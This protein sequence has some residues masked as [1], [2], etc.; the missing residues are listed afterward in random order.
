MADV[1]GIVIMLVTRGQVGAGR[2][3]GQRPLAGSVADR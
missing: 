2:A 1:P 3:G